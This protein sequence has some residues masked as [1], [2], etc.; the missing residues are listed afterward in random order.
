VG[1]YPGRHT[2]SS[3]N[4]SKRAGLSR[5]TP[6]PWDL[7]P[8]ETVWGIMKKRLKMIEYEELNG[9]RS[10]VRDGWGAIAQ[11]AIRTFAQNFSHR[12][13]VLIAAR[14]GRISRL[15]LSRWTCLKAGDGLDSL[16]LRSQLKRTL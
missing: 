5:T 11:E 14:G 4:V 12:C 8:I 3:W 13:E 7:S 16:P 15:L 10:V 1:H 2:T 9:L 6:H